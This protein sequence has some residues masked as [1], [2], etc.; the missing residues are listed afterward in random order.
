MGGRAG[1][2]KIRALYVGWSPLPRD[3]VNELT[4]AEPSL[5][6]TVTTR[7]GDV[8]D[9]LRDG[10]D[11]LIIDEKK[12]QMDATRMAFNIRQRGFLSLQIVIRRRRAGQC[13][14]REETLGVKVLLDSG[15]D[16]ACAHKLAETIAGLTY[17][18]PSLEVKREGLSA[19]IGD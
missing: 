5:D 4:E 15:R 6:L 13:W 14:K 17:T 8:L 2:G 9:V 12:P 18:A 11:C 7:Y 10:Y 19:P 1:Q 3:Y 16:S